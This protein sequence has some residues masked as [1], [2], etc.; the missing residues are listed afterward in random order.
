VH[1]VRAHLKLP[2]SQRFTDYRQMADAIL[3][4]KAADA[5]AVGR[6]HIAHI[7]AVLDMLPDSAFAP[8]PAPSPEITVS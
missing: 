7:A 8:E 4:G 6:A 3:S 1:L 5:E 2:R